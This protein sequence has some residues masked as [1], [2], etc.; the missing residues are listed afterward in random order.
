MKNFFVYYDLFDILKRTYRELI[1]S[2]SEKPKI[3]SYLLK[4]FMFFA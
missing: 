2:N 3:N 1:Y 4:N